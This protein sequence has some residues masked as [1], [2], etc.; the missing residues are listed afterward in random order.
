MQLGAVAEKSWALPVDHWGQL[1]VH[2]TDLLSILL[3]CNGFARIQETVVDHTGSRLPNSD[4]DLFLVQDWLWEVFWS[5]SVVQP[6]SCS[7]P[8]AAKWID[9]EDS[10]LSAMSQTE[11]IQH[12]NT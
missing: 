8:F 9:L 12:N 6:L 2:L 5:M 4:L 3:R 7:S 10:M 11:K 1:S